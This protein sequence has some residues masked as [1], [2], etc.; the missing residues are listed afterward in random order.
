M[1]VTGFLLPVSLQAQAEKDQYARIAILRPF[2]GKTVDFE[3]GY[4]RHLDWHKKAGDR[5]VW[6]GWSI[7]ASDRQRWFVYATFG[8]TAASLDS[9]VAPAEDEKDNIINVVPHCE[10]KENAL[11]KYLPDV[12]IGNGVPKP[13][14]RVEMVTVN[15]LTGAAAEFE[16]ALNKHKATLTRET[17]WFRLV[18]G[19][20]VPRYVCLRTYPSLSALLNGSSE[21]LIPEKVNRIIVKQTVEI[22]AL[23]PTMSYG[24][25][26]NQ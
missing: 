10:F 14:A 7:W 22:L 8:H 12:S 4:A 17:L 25:P 16:A 19:A 15:L 13:T 9:S 2:D 11:Y 20:A 1:A 18:S 6:Y 5:W 23:R 3:A 21:Q 24:L 26:A